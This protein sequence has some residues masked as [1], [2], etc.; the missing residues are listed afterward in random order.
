MISAVRAAG[1]RA[2]NFD[3]LAALHRASRPCSTATPAPQIK[4]SWFQN[5]RMA[6]P[7]DPLAEDGAR[8]SRKRYAHSYCLRL[9]PFSSPG[10][11]WELLGTPPIA[12]A[13][14]EDCIPQSLYPMLNI[15]RDSSLV[16]PEANQSFR[17]NA[18]PS[19]HITPQARRMAGWEGAQRGHWARAAHHHWDP[20]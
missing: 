8:G 19:M 16:A 3:G 2:S 6:D 7:G 13:S 5:L 1:S 20:W 15:P 17:P 14:D 18:H 9:A 4:S 10:S 12:A 11:R